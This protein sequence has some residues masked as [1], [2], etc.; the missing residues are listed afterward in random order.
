MIFKLASLLRKSTMS[1]ASRRRTKYI[2]G[3]AIFFALL[4]G[5]PLERYFNKPP[6]C[7]DGKQ[8]QGETAPDK[9]G[10]CPLLDERTLAPASILWAR[11]FKVRDGLYSSVAY[12]EN[13]NKDAGVRSVRYRFGLYDDKNILVAERAGVMFVMPGSITPVFEGNIDTG[14]RAVAHTYFEFNE[15]LVW[16]RLKNIAS[17]VITSDERISDTRTT[18]RVEAIVENI[19]VAPVSDLLFVAV[20]FSPSGNARAASKT[21]ISRLFTGEKR[22]VVFTWPETFGV[23][24]GRVDVMTLIAPVP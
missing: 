1:W 5:V 15:P 4:V 14:N 16:E 24:V 10:P 22:R 3:I 19:S 12:I 18:P 8:N 2:I 11:S 20:V 21:T 17:S 6:S 13:P 9:G 23:Q 7:S